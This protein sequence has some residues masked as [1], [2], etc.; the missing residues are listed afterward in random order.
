MIADSC[1]GSKP[2]NAAVLSLPSQPSSLKESLADRSG[3]VIINWTRAGPMA[4]PASSSFSQSPVGN[5][6]FLRVL[7]SQYLTG[8]IRTYEYIDEGA[9]PLV[10]H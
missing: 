6:C 2:A 9:D 7:D 10:S 3:G 5:L 4:S 8:L 1:N